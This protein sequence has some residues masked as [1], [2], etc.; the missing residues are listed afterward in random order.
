M[1]EYGCHSFL[2]G[3]AMLIRRI[4]GCSCMWGWSVVVSWRTE[5][6]REVI[7]AGT[8]IGS[9]ASCTKKKAI[10]TG[11]RFSEKYQESV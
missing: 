2:Q 8:V 5:V 7:L 6:V 10:V 11:E 4:R 3:Y 9:A 1:L